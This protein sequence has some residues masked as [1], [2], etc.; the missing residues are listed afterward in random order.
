MSICK[1]RQAGPCESTVFSGANF[2]IGFNQVKNPVMSAKWYEEAARQGHAK[3]AA[4]TGLNYELGV[5]GSILQIRTQPSTGIRFPPMQAILLAC[6]IW[7]LPMKT[8]L[9]QPSIREKHWNVT[10]KA[11]KCRIEN[12]RSDT[13]FFRIRSMVSRNLP[14][15]TLHIAGTMRA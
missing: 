13:R 15:K 7:D 1:S 3:A 14:M 9:A 6:I 11:R 2:R 8:V 12:A 10:G 5:E 4:Y